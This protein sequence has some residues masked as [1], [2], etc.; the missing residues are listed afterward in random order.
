MDYKEYISFI[1]I[2]FLFPSNFMGAVLLAFLWNIIDQCM[3]KE[4]YSLE[5]I[6]SHINK[7]REKEQQ[8]EF[9][10]LLLFYYIGHYLRNKCPL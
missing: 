9:V 1:I 6:V 8:L 10:T 7:Y 3:Y 4:S 5:F 2:G